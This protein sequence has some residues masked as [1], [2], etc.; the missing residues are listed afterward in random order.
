MVC[1]IVL[2]WVL[3]LVGFDLR[4]RLAVCADAV[5][6]FVAVVW[7]LDICWVCGCGCLLFAFWFVACVM[8]LCCCLWWV[9]NVSV[10][11]FNCLVVMCFDYGCLVNLARCWRFVVGLFACQCCW[12]VCGLGDC[13]LVFGGA[14]LLLRVCL[15]LV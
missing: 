4:L 2:F 12:F 15:Y 14:A 10:S 9:L 11:W 1:L 5:C 7:L 8:S 13:D 3:R 6:W